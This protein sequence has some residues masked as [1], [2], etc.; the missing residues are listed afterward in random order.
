MMNSSPLHSIEFIRV[1]VFKMI[2]HAVFETFFVMTRHRSALLKNQK[3][4]LV[5][6]T[7]KNENQACVGCESHVM[8][9]IYY[10]VLG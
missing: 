7:R 9:E 2:I 1:S 10:Y 5:T 4:I 3:S 8:R 6:R